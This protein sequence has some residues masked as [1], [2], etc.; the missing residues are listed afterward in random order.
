MDRRITLRRHVKSQSA[1]GAA[2]ETPAVVATV[3]AERLPESGTEA[4]REGQRQGWAVVVWR[5][6]YLLDGQNEP[7]VEWSLLDGVREY[8]ILEV[9]E[10]GRRDGWEL[11]TRFRSEDQRV[12]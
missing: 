10:L 5:V 6:R 9:R 4:F 11:V 1:A 2:V 8:E 7:T 3:W 12:A